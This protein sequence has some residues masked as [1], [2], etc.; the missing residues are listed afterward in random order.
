MLLSR[1]VQF[2]YKLKDIKKQ[3][4]SDKYIPK[5]LSKY[6]FNKQQIFTYRIKFKTI[7]FTIAP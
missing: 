3:K 2:T 7:L 5:K 4:K 6:H 1:Y